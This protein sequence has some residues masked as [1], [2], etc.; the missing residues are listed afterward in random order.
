MSAT[1]RTMQQFQ[2]VAKSR[3]AIERLLQAALEGDKQRIERAVSANPGLAYESDET[4]RT[5]LMNAALGYH[6][7]LVGYLLGKGASIHVKDKVHDYN[8]LR[9]AKEGYKMLWEKADNDEA[10][11]SLENSKRQMIFILGNHLD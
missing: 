2:S 1:L 6:Y 5:L 3:S 9:F 4:G 10:R 7:D 11:A 8:A